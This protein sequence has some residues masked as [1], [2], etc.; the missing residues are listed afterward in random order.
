MES[1]SLKKLS[2]LELVLDRY[3]YYVLIN[4]NHKQQLTKSI[5]RGLNTN[6]SE[7]QYCHA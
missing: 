4:K 6:P 2:L 7:T 1:K 3:M 5:K